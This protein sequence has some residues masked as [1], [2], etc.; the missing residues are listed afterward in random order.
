MNFWS[1]IFR[2]K[3]GKSLLQRDG[4]AEAERDEE[5]WYYKE[6]QDFSRSQSTI[7]IEQRRP[8]DWEVL[9]SSCGIV[10][11]NNSDRRSEVSRFFAGTYRW[12][13][14]ERTVE[15]FH[16]TNSIRIL[17]TYSDNRGKERTVHL[18]FL[19]QELAG[20]LEREDIRKLWGRIRFIKFPS[21]GRN[22]KYLIRFDLMRQKDPRRIV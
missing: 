2:A 18:G 13:R 12:L 6:S 4:V 14:L 8:G 11:L 3:G 15:G 20:D 22:S 5:G 10:D 16:A 19:K 21:P 1:V 9:E 17:G 7:R